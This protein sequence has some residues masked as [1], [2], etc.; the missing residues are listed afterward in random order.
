MLYR[1]VTGRTYIDLFKFRGTSMDINDIVEA[2]DNERELIISEQKR[3]YSSKLIDYWNIHE[4]KY[5]FFRQSSDIDEITSS[6]IK[7][8]SRRVNIVISLYR[9]QAMVEYSLLNDN[10]GILYDF[11]EESL[12]DNSVAIKYLK[13]L[14]GFRDKDITTETVALMNNTAKYHTSLAL[15]S[16]YYENGKMSVLIDHI[17]DMFDCVESHIE[18]YMSSYDI[19]KNSDLMKAEILSD[20]PHMMSGYLNKF[21]RYIVNGDN[22]IHPTGQGWWLYTTPEQYNITLNGESFYKRQG[23]VVKLY[24]HYLMQ[25][26]QRLDIPH[27]EG[28]EE[29]HVYGHGTQ[30]VYF[31]RPSSSLKTIHCYNIYISYCYRKIVVDHPLTY[32]NTTTT[33]LSCS[34]MRIEND[35]KITYH[36]RPVKGILSSN[37]FIPILNEPNY[38]AILHANM[39]NDIIQIGHY[40]E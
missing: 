10:E 18:K 5:I 22:I 31:S 27:F 39:N 6:L 40:I 14:Y 23:N 7:I 28:V 25:H 33:T 8:L 29:L 26:Y 13:Y 17:N 36:T 15:T 16:L 4:L 19:E 20:M 2:T 9:I 30:S 21:I 34:V 37:C 38:D 24:L 3:N 32:N 11:M 12:D 1:Q 35:G